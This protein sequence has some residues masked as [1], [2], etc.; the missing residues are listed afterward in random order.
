MQCLQSKQIELELIPDRYMF[1]FFEKSTRGGISHICNRHGKASNMSLKSY[2]LKQKWKHIMYLD[3]NNF[4][5]CA[6]CKF[7]PTSGLKWIDGK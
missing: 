1:R 2:N 7:F 5:G 3:T 4:Y 6:M